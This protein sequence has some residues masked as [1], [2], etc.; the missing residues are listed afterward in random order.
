MAAKAVLLGIDHTMK[1]FIAIGTIT[2]TGNYG[3]A[4]SHGDVLDLSA[5]GVPAS[6]TT[7]PVVQ[8][9]EMPTVTAGVAAVSTLYRF[10]YAAA[11]TQA[12]GMLQI[13]GAAAEYTAGAAYGANVPNT[14][15][16]QAYF[17]AF[18]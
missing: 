4:A 10:I 11:T 13:M 2:L 12:L 1:G 16:F 5:L 15:I 7:V 17:P 6:N 14:L 18:L 8:I 9:W 3:T